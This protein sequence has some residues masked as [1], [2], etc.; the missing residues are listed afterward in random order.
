MKIHFLDVGQ[1]QYGDC[2]LVRDGD[3]SILIDAA[4]KGDFRGSSGHP[5]IPRQLRDLM[6]QP[7][8]PVELS[9]LVLTHCHSDHIGCL[10][11]M[12]ER[13]VIAP[14][15]ALVADEFAG[16]GLARDETDADRKRFRVLASLQEEPLAPGASDAVIEQFIADAASQRDLY[17]AMLETLEQRGTEVI[18]YK[19]DAATVADLERRFR[20]VGLKIL[21]PTANQ[22][23]LC[24]QTIEQFSSD[25]VD[26]LSSLSGTDLDEVA[27][28]RTLTEGQAPTDVILPDAVFDFL[29]RPGAGAAKNNQSIVI[30]VGKGSSRSLLTGDMQFAVAEVD[31]LDAEMATLLD[32]VVAA[33]PYAFIKLPHHASYNA[34][35]ESVLARFPQTRCFGI[36]TGRNGAAH[37]NP[38]VL[39]L[40]KNAAPPLEWA[41]TDKNGQFSVDVTRGQVRFTISEGRLSDP[42]P[43]P[44]DEVMSTVVEEVSITPPALPPEASAAE[45]EQPAAEVRNPPA[46]DQFVEITARIPAS[47]PRVTITVEID[48]GGRGGAAG[49]GPDERPRRTAQLGGGRS[50]P[51]LLFVT[52]PQRLRRKVGDQAYASV[53]AMVE[54]GGG[55]LL[56]TSGQTPAFNTIGRA[57]AGARGVVILGD[58]NVVPALIYDV[59]PPDLRRRISARRDP[60]Q[61]VVWSDQQ[62]G[63]TDGD[64]LG[65]LPVSRIPDGSSGEFLLGCLAAGDARTTQAKFGSRNAERPFAA[66][67]FRRLGGTGSLMVSGPDDYAGVQQRH[68]EARQLYFML[69]GSDSDATRFWG[70]DEGG[71]V[72]AINLANLSQGVAAPGA[73]VLTGCCWGALTVQEIASRAR[74]HS[75]VSPRTA[76]SSLAL[77][78]LEL[79]ALAFVGCTGAH[80]S[81]LDGQLNFFGEPMHR[82][83][84]AGYQQG[85][86]PAQALFD[87]K[88]AYIREM[89]H[90]RV[91]APE[92]AIEY[93][94]LRQFTCLGL[95]W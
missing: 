72:E 69:H 95:G 56:E 5:S 58:Y 28:Y 41:R 61:F 54:Q 42:Q 85:S 87:A 84:W 32:K 43:K 74:D 30:S 2:I 68:F 53:R 48:Q 40:L 75:T 6:E 38:K 34:F 31:G 20:D 17:I 27:L 33:G 22:L 14:K 62:Y 21:G 52:D 9:L 91:T 25:A 36:S 83:F 64:G 8:G 60:D 47:L 46:S 66:D 23:V 93:K 65:E 49:R 86:A 63:D 94:I 51:K 50:L 19:G 89:P 12:V 76:Q 4:H 13:E 88:T 55:T 15:V 79:G 59:L 71:S 77:R 37:P 45:P 3:T 35:E 16:Y 82:A 78:F 29:D 80:Y 7:D 18:R 44:L 67:I 39:R 73:T 11:E 81:P 26:A 24:A 57:A 90:G 10:P 1:S 70:E 92:W